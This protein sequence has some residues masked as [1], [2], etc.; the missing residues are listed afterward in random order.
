MNKADFKI[1]KGQIKNG[2]N[3]TREIIQGHTVF[4]AAT[5]CASLQSRNASP[6]AVTSWDTR[7]DGR[8]CWRGKQGREMER[9]W[10][11]A[12][13]E[14]GKH[15]NMGFMLTTKSPKLLTI[16]QQLVKHSPLAQGWSDFSCKGDTRT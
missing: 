10:G 5:I 3:S 6:V 9:K 4:S 16:G 12:I 13:E 15:M 11:E 1:T 2:N 8:R 7:K 14:E